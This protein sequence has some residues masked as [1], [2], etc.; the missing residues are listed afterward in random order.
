MK[1]QKYKQIILKR[2]SKFTPHNL[3]LNNDYNDLAR[4]SIETRSSGRLLTCKLIS[5]DPSSTNE[6]KVAAESI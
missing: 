5:Y 6:T 3:E 1:N 2:T 4:K